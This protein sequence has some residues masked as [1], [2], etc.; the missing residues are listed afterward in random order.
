MALS[1][2]EGLK[3]LFLWLGIILAFLV[4]MALSPN[5]GLKLQISPQAPIYCQVGMGLSP[6]EGLKPTCVQVTIT[7][8][9]CLE[10]PQ[11]PTEDQ[12]HYIT[13]PHTA[14]LLFSTP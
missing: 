11:P 13:V 7:Y 5:E 3:L 10:T 8:N 9:I 1:A 14:A 4:G 6:N 2:N 12:K